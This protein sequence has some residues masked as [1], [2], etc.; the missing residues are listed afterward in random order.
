MIKLVFV[1][2]LFFIVSCEITDF[3]S[4]PTTV[5]APENNTVLLPCYLNTA[6]T[7]KFPKSF[8][9]ALIVVLKF[10]ITVYVAIK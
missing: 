2:A 5:K 6:S 10:N 9:F 3:A 8:V 7:G 1:S 4:A